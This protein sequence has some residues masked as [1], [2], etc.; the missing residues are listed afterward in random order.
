MGLVPAHLQAE[1]H[2]VLSH[3]RR[4]T[5]NDACQVDAVRRYRAAN[6]EGLVVEIKAVSEES[7]LNH[8]QDFEL[9]EG[10]K[11][12]GANND[13]KSV[14]NGGFMTVKEVRATDCD[15]LDEFGVEFTL[16]HAQ[17]ARCSRLAWAITVTSSQSREFDGK[18]C[19]WDL[20]S[21]H[22]SRA[23]LYVAAT[24]VKHGSLLIVAS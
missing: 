20:G 17:V 11:L 8:Q 24:R 15:I 19:L 1:T 23:H 4:T 3:R 5:L 2:L 21:K 7:G 9:S 12:I 18:V 16:T 14:V 13:L 6:P 22:Y 10:T